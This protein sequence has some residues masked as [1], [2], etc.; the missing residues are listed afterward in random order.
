[1]RKQLFICTFVRIASWQALRSTSKEGGRENYR[2]FPIF[3][4]YEK[5]V[6][7]TRRYTVHKYTLPYLR[8]LL[9]NLKCCWLTSV[10]CQPFLS[11]IL[12]F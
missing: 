8:R 1:M 6:N 12:Y 2:L 10:M 9:Y 4:L 7:L 5:T 3:I 11:R